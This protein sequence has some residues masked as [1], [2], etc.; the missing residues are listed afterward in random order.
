[1]NVT[2]VQFVHILSNNSEILSLLIT[3]SKLET[4][5]KKYIID[6]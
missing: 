2:G 6:I 3:G 5:P 1:M 4:S